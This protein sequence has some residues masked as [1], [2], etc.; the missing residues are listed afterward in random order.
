MIQHQTNEV[1]ESPRLEL[2]QM[3]H[4]K[5]SEDIQRKPVSAT[6]VEDHLNELEEKKAQL[7]EW[8][9]K[10]AEILNIL[11]L[12]HHHALDDQPSALHYHVQALDIYKSQRDQC[13]LQKEIAVTILDIGNVHRSMG[14]NE[15]AV[16]SYESALR[17]FSQNGFPASHPLVSSATRSLSRLTRI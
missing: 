4:D 3:E 7:G 9:P 5:S 13:S 1:L 6:F 8:H 2:R 10:I 15:Q 16:A 14:N 17:I 11:G 12:F